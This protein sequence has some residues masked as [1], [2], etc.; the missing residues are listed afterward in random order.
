MEKEKIVLAYSGGLDTSI[1]IRWLQ[2]ERG[3]E[4]VALA[5]D[6]GQGDDL[7]SVKNKALQIGAAKSYLIDA[8]IEFIDDFIIPA[9]KANAL[10]EGKYPLV[11]AL[12]RPLIAKWQVE[13]ADTE[14]ANFVAHGCTGKGNDQVRFE[15]SI[16][17]LN[18]DLKIIAPLREWSMS[19]E[20]SMEY[21]KKHNIPVPTSKE[22]PYSIDENLWG[23]A[24]ECGGLEDPWN[25]PP[26]DIYELTAD[27]D[28]TPN[29]PSYLEIDFVQGIPVGLDGNE[30]NLLDLIERVGKIAGENGYGRLDMIEN[31]LVGIKSREVYE[32]PAALS[33]I[34]AHQS[35]EDLTLERDLLHYKSLIEQKYAELIYYGLWFSPLKNAL[36]AFVNE[37]QKSVTGSV[38]LKFYKGTCRVVGRKSN[39]SLY[40][41]SL[42]TYEEADKF[43]HDSAK[44]F[45]DLWGLPV[46][47]WARRQRKT[48]E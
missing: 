6:V 45:I 18:P 5:V 31:R 19:R 41:Y 37:T 2:E 39:E 30:V 12:S 23:R 8:R 7:E 22:K 32:A 44:G 47:V 3:G 42:A 24:I 33:L 26:S 43:S 28:N 4:V 40:D 27:V 15:V 16:G 48:G 9:L 34:L 11:S 38:R 1:A 35:L 25:E 14:K 13:V 29:K 10:Y 20:K 17:A 36:D 21:A 46:R